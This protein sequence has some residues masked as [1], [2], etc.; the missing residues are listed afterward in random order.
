MSGLKKSII[1]KKLLLLKE[2]I[3]SHDYNITNLIIDIDYSI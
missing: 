2:Q 1:K 3:Y